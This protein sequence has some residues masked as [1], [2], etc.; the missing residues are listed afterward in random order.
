VARVAKTITADRFMG[1]QVALWT[2][3]CRHDT[4]SSLLP[5]VQF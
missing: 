3:A 1:L 2:D 5:A 4:L